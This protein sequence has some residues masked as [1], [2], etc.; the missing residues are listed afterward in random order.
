MGLVLVFAIA[1]V[2]AVVRLIRLKNLLS[3][4]WRR[5][6]ANLYPGGEFAYGLDSEL[7]PLLVLRIGLGHD[8]PL[9]DLP[10][11]ICEIALVLLLEVL[12]SLL[13]GTM[14]LIPELAHESLPTILLTL[15]L[16]GILR[17][18]IDDLRNEH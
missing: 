6:L 16:E 13:V 18:V 9:E 17:L 8:E 10:I 5:V 15:V 11:Y 2:R 14:L 3:H 1:T 7:L 4:L 12:L